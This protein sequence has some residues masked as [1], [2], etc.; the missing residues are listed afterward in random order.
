[1]NTQFAYSISPVFFSPSPNFVFTRETSIHD[2]PDISTGSVMVLL[3]FWFSYL[4]DSSMIITFQP[5]RF[6]CKF[7]FSTVLVVP[8]IW[9]SYHFGPL[10]IWICVFQPVF[11]PSWI[12][13]PP[14]VCSSD[15]SGSPAILFLLP[16]YH[17]YYY[18]APLLGC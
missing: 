18:F 8:T 6:S 1:M 9:E 12:P 17:S 15:Q 3:P 14:P 7:L 11:Q 2:F 16:F 5:F 4:S 13:I 10:P